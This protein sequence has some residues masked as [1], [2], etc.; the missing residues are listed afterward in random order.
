M[1][2]QTLKLTRTM[3]GTWSIDISA[4]STQ[5]DTRKWPIDIGAV[6]KTQTDEEMIGR[7]SFDIGV[8][9]TQKTQTQTDRKM[10]DRYR[11]GLKMQTNKTMTDRYRC[12]PKNSKWT[13][14]DRKIVNRYG[15]GLNSNWHDGWPINID[16]VPT[17]AKLTWWWSNQ[18]AQSQRITRITMQAN[19]AG[20]DMP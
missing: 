2:S 6:S 1:R 7:W 8:V 17:Q 14:T 12:G 4:T 16:A 11:C 15:C 9:P 5:T 20:R 19:S 13:Q 10:V 3:I 18:V